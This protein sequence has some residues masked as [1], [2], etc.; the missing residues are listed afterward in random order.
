MLPCFSKASVME[1]TKIYLGLIAVWCMVAWMAWEFAWDAWQS[2]RR[3][4]SLR[5][6]RENARK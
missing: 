5:R 3:L 6:D 1:N 4:R 2:N